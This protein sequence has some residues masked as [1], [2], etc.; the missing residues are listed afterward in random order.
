MIGPDG[1]NVPA[2]WVSY[3]RGGCDCGAVAT[4][5]VVLENTGTGATGDVAK[6]FG[7]GSPQWNQ[8]VASNSA[9]AGTAARAKAQTDFVGFAIHC[10]QG[11]AI[12]ANGHDDLLPQEVGG[13]DG[14]KGLF[15]AQ[16]I[17]PLLTAQHATV[18]LTD[19]LAQPITDP[20]GQ[21]GFPGFDGM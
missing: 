16:G 7:N 6:V 9:P 2:P 4:A 1:S 14:F 12:C 13:Y 10:A 21:P 18:P 5:N 17:N 8:A 3:T 15:G 19:L 20:F 11:S